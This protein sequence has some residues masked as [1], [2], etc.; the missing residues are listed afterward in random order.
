MVPFLA[1]HSAFP[2]HP[3]LG[4]LVNKFGVAC[5]VSVTDTNDSAEYI[6]YIILRLLIIYGTMPFP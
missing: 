5:E 2:S 4:Q 1:H 6:D 3:P